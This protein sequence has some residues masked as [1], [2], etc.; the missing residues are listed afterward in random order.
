MDCD[1][2]PEVECLQTC[3][4]LIHQFRI[5]CLIS[6]KPFAVLLLACVIVHQAPEF[7]QRMDKTCCQNFVAVCQGFEVMPE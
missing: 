2:C 4:R 7:F 5:V 1:L 6:A 3:I